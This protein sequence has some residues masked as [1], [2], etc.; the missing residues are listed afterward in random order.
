[1]FVLVSTALIVTIMSLAIR[2]HTFEEGDDEN[3][4]K[5]QS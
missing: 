1:M 5:I 4:I 3:T 2:G